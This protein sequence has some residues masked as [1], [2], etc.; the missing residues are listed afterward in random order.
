MTKP[1][2]APEAPLTRKQLSR[3]ERE[4][5]QRRYVLITTAVVALLVVGL[6]AAGVINETV[7]K[8]RQP[9]AR[10]GDDT[11]SRREFATTAR[12]QRFQL[13]DRFQRTV[14][15][16]QLLA[17]DPQSEQMFNQQLQQIQTTLN[18]P[19]TLG[20]QVLEALVDDRLVRQEAARRGI[21]VTADEV[22][23]A[24]RERIF[25]FYPNGTPT[26]TVT[27]TSGPTDVPSAT[28]TVDPTRAATLTAAP[29]LTPTATLTPTET[30]A[31]TATSTPG[32]S[33]TPSATF[34]PRPSATPFTA[35]GY[36]TLAAQYQGDLWREARVSQPDIRHLLETQ[37]LREKLEAAMGAEVSA[38]AEQVHARHI[39]VP[40]EAV[41]VVV[42]ER[43]KN[44]EDFATLAAELSTDTASKDKGGDLGWF[45]KGAMIPE[46]EQAAFSQP[47]GEIGAPVK[48]TYGYHIIQ[49]LERGERPLDAAALEQARQQALSDW[50]D[51]QRSATMADG[52][53]V[54]EIYDNWLADVPSQPALPTG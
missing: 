14:E 7:I 46:F 22:E 49:V 8:P 39:L 12:F 10:V 17:G 11:I 6:V 44:G 47:V 3:V 32:P 18:D 23:Q 19:A 52:R 27:P 25:Q 16:A 34:T 38:T 45:G 40:D 24:Y 28:P 53:P 21:T 20:R 2:P 35:E 37:L 31:P 26:P 29:T 41:A 5:R 43:L 13:V 42:A 9:V 15:L 50:L 33:P 48:T 51:S 30:L 54:V 4:R 36:A 1:R